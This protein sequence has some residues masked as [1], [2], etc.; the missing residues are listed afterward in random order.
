MVTHRNPSAREQKDFDPQNF[1]IV[2]DRFLQHNQSVVRLESG[3][4]LRTLDWPQII[5]REYTLVWH[6]IFFGAK[7]IILKMNSSEK[8][9]TQSQQ[10][11]C[12][13]QV[14]VIVED[15][16]G[17]LFPLTQDIPKCLLPIA[18]RPLL[19]YT[20]DTIRN[21]GALGKLCLRLYL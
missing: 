17:R 8:N 18:N 11:K 4:L 6:R 21:S 16:D 13:F 1:Q 19:A 9:E 20:L 10:L 14:I 5:C 7:N 2:S 12:E 3:T 15:D